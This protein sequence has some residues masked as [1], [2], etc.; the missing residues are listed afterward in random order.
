MEKLVKVRP[1]IRKTDSYKVSHWKQYPPGTEDVFS[2]WE[3]RGGKFPT[4]TFF[5]L[6]YIC[7]RHLTGQVFDDTDIIESREK[8]A[9]HFGDRTLFNE[10]AWWYILKE[11][12]GVLPLHIRA[13]PEG[14][15]VPTRNVL[16]TVHTTDKKVPWLT[17]YAETL[18]SQVW[19]PTTVCTQSRAMRALL[20]QY[21]IET[22]GDPGVVDF[23]LHDFGY[24]GAT[25]DEAAGIGDA[26]HLVNFRGT[27]TW[28]GID[29]V[30]NHY[31]DHMAGNSIPAMEH[32]TVTSWGREH[33]GD[34][35]ENAMDVNP[36]GLLSIVGDSYDIY[37]MCRELLGKRLK[38]KILERD[39]RIIVRPDSGYPP[40][41]VLKVLEILGEAFGYT[42]NAKGYTVLNPKVRVIQGDGIDYEML[43][44]ILAPMKAA[45]WA[46]ENLAFGS[47]GGLIQKVDRDTQKCAIKC[48]AICINGVWRDVLKDP[49]TDPGKKSKA[50]LL[51]LVKNSDGYQTVRQGSDKG[52]D[53]LVDYL[54]NG[55]MKYDESFARIRERALLD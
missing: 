9:D 27:D 44:T 26:A 19:Y 3:S 45:L 7:D 22:G 6:K 38:L 8:F 36:T 52:T 48:S 49:I 29:L 30:A 39:G 55:E 17:N 33:E 42:V 2:F 4:T 11:H 37:N 13:V 41:V 14:T 47:G 31:H 16:M 25:C 18:L 53:L 12:G 50:G 1:F 40:E 20:V 35:Y 43:G 46:A 10:Q 23:M 34:A 21:V 51:M 15:T 5:G 24:R 32:S 28:A 54:V